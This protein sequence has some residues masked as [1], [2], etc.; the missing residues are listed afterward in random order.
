MKVTPNLPSLLP[1]LTFTILPSEELAEKSYLHLPSPTFTVTFTPEIPVFPMV[2]SKSE[3]SEG[4][5][6]HFQVACAREF[7]RIAAVLRFHTTA[8]GG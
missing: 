3:G 6:E 7:A 4:K 2:F 1:S 5:I 8:S